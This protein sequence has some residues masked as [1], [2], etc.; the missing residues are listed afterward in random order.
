MDQKL[1]VL[2]GVPLFAG[3]PG[4]ELEE[5][6]RL[7]DEVSLKAGHVIAREGTSGSEFFVILDGT[8]AVTKGGEHLRDM[9]RGDFFGELALLGH[10]PRTASVTCTTDGEFLVLGRREFSQLLADYPSIQGAVLQALA[11][12]IATLAPDHTH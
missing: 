8:V 2:A 9:G 11:S 4:R 12:R 10:V 1:Q 3:L 6:G 5:I 7:C